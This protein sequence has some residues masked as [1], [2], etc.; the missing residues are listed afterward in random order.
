MMEARWL[1]RSHL[2]STMRIFL[3]DVL[4]DSPSTE[5]PAYVDSNSNGCAESEK[6]NTD[7][8][9]LNNKRRRRWRIS[10]VG[11]RLRIEE[12]NATFLSCG[13]D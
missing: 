1:R 10:H 5:S 6:D 13:I 11:G 2:R 9:P 3:A 12:A 8:S 4:V 7:G